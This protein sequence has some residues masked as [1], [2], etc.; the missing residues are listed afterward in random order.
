[1]PHFSVHFASCL[2][3]HHDLR[4]SDQ[5]SDDADGV[6][7]PVGEFVPTVT[8]ICPKSAAHRREASFNTVSIQGMLES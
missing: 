4:V 5:R 6:L 1:M 8:Q 7:L 2:V 3:Q